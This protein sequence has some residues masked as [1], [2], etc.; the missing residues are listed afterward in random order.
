[1]ASQHAEKRAEERERERER[2]RGRG[3]GRGRERERE[4]GSTSRDGGQDGGDGLGDHAL[5]VLGLALAADVDELL[6][7]RALEERVALRE[8]DTADH[9]VL[10]EACEKR[11]VLGRIVSLKKCDEAR[12]RH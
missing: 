2:E 9:V 4:E 6:E 7:V 10:D 12:G 1:M 5:D 8:L 3:R 11:V